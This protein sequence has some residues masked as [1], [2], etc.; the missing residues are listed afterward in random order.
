MK[1]KIYPND[2]ILA[3]S[4]YLAM[5]NMALDNTAIDAELSKCNDKTWNEISGRIRQHC[6]RMFE[7]EADVDGMQ[8]EVNSWVKEFKKGD[9]FSINEWEN[10]KRKVGLGV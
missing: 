4:W 1:S 10:Y 3:A 9:K 5:T 6:F 2:E 7:G 8:D